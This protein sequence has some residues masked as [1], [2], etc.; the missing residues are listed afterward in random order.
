M[1]GTSGKKCFKSRGFSKIK[2]ASV[3]YFSDASETGY[4]QTSYLRLV[5]EDN[6]ILCSLLIRKSR[7]TPA[8]YVSAP[9]LELAAATMSIKMSQLINRELEL[10][11][12]TS[13]REHFWTNRQ[14]VF[15]CINNESK[16]FKCLWQSAADSWQ[17]KY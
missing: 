11:D 15:G 16:R 4:R 9:R 1:N 7:V 12:V 13:I 17:F 10:N 5:S 2:D 6:Q 14:V 3:H 8:K